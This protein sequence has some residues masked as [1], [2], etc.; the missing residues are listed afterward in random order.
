M[1]C[2]NLMNLN[3]IQVSLQIILPQNAHNKP[4]K[5]I[6]DNDFAAE[7]QLY[8]FPVTLQYNSQGCAP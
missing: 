7:L 5:Q 2:E 4:W 6:I 8:S 1:L 3:R